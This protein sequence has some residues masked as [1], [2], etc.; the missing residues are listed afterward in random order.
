MKRPGWEQGHAGT[1]LTG[2][3]LGHNRAR[4][5]GE[6]GTQWAQ[7]AAD[8]ECPQAGPGVRG[9]EQRAQQ[10][11]TS[12]RSAQSGPRVACW[13][14]TGPGLRPET[15]GPNL[16]LPLNQL[17]GP[18]AEHPQLAT[19]GVGGTP[20]TRGS[21]AVDQAP[22][23]PGGQGSRLCW[24]VTDRGP[25]RPS[26]LLTLPSCP[27]RWAAGAGL[28]GFRPRG[29]GGLWPQPHG[30][31]HRQALPRRGPLGRTS[32][33][34]SGPLSS[35]CLTPPPPAAAPSASDGRACQ[36]RVPVPVCDSGRRARGDGRP[37]LSPSKQRQRP[38]S[39]RDRVCP[40][41]ESRGAG[42]RP[43]PPPP[44]K[45]QPAPRE[46]SQTARRGHAHSLCGSCG[47]S[48]GQTST[49][50]ASPE[51]ESPPLATVHWGGC[52]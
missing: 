39:P 7:L 22:G 30:P 20:V 25:G 48:R 16:T 13:A 36:P 19:S 2:M 50:V 32:S 28:A 47:R 3:R 9:S 23:Q 38:H 27:R 34:I 10:R 15:L 33:L 31:G 24:A 40:G 52:L 29:G 35:S 8:V 45:Q 37:R 46:F 6:T 42:R 18:S 5:G 1:P 49:S 21:R 43:L 11:E 26:A 44:R 51:D 4:R 17:S 41:E 14:G 12:P